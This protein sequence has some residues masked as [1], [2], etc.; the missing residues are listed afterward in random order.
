MQSKY[1]GCADIWSLGITAIELAKG[2]PPY[3][4]KVHPFQV[5]FLIPKSP[6]PKLEGDEFTSIFKDFVAQCL[7]KDPAS[8]PS[9]ATLLAHPFITSAEKLPE[10]EEF[11]RDRV[12][13][14][15]WQLQL[16]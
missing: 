7:V 4:N 12:R 16:N 5:I 11:I 2:T 10:W 9:A 6:P 1:D 8:R 15:S 3:A 13:V 14:A